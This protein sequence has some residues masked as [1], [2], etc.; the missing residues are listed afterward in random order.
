[1]ET[2]NKNT[3][4]VEIPANWKIMDEG[5]YSRVIGLVNTAAVIASDLKDETASL[6]YPLLDTALL[7]FDEAVGVGDL[8]AKIDEERRKQQ[9]RLSLGYRDGYH[10]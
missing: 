3:V 8:F 6:L 10:A 5:E 4:T 1:M 9:Y 7:I 2:E